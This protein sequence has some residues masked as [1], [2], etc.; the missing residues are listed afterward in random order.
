MYP[1]YFAVFRKGWAVVN[2]VDCDRGALGAPVSQTCSGG[3]AI[4]IVWAETRL[5]PRYSH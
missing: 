4:D 5:A 2:A 3:Y 1:A